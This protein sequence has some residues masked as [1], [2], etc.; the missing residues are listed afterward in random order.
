[1]MLLLESVD[2]GLVALVALRSEGSDLYE[3][4]GTSADGRRYEDCPVAIDRIDYDVDHFRHV[5]GVCYG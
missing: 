4:V 2:E 5:L 3:C 1:M